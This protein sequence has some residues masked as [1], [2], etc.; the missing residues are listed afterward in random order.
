MSLCHKLVTLLAHYV[1][2]SPDHKVKL[3]IEASLIFDFHKDSPLIL[4]VV[5]ELSGNFHFSEV[6]IR[7]R[8]L[9]E[10]IHKIIVLVYLTDNLPC[11]LLVCGKLKQLLQIWWFIISRGWWIQGILVYDRYDRIFYLVFLQTACGQSLG[12]DGRGCHFKA[13]IIGIITDSHWRLKQFFY[14]PDSRAIWFRCRLRYTFKFYLR[15]SDGQIFWYRR[16]AR[17]LRMY[18]YHII[19]WLY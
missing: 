12:S 5:F 15:L 19:T 3:G 14:N 9:G 1:V 4:L 8:K 7:F 10:R 13:G 11:T 18:Y 16:D 2:E 17:W 6:I